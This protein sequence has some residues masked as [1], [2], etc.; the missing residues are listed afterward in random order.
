MHMMQ[1]VS[2]L[3]LEKPP[4]FHANLERFEEL[5]VGLAEIGKHNVSAKQS[6]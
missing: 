2:E 6:H 4:T 5:I 3:N 1:L